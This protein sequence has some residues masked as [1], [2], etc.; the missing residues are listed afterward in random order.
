ME[1]PYFADRPV[2]VVPFSL[3]GVPLSI[4]LEES[5]IDVLSVMISGVW[6]RGDG[7]GVGQGWG[8]GLMVKALPGDG[9]TPGVGK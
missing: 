7:L 4:G 2:W 6:P 8:R 3:R 1:T 5:V 9:L